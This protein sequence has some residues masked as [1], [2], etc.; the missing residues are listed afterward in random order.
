MINVKDNCK[1][2]YKE[3]M[4]CKTCLLFSETQEHLFLCSGIR[5]HLKNIKF[6][7][8]CYNMLDR[9]L[10]EQEKFAKIYTLILETRTDILSQTEQ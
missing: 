3:N 1:T 5:K 6:D 4:W 2:S 10:V 7:N 8:Y 9:N